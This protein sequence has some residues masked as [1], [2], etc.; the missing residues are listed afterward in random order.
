MKKTII[1]I[2]ILNHIINANSQ[3]YRITSTLFKPGWYVGVNGGLN[4]YIAEGNEFWY[5]NKP[6]IFSI[7][8]NGGFVAHAV[9]GYEFTPLWGLRGSVGY[10][11]HNWP[12]IRINQIIPFNAENLTGDVTLNLSNWWWKSNPRRL[13]SLTAF[14]GIGL[15]HREKANFP[16]DFYAGILRGGIQGDFH[17]SRTM[18]VNLSAEGNFVDDNYNNYVAHTPFEMYAVLTFG[19]TYHLK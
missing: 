17:L 19:V 2:L 9:V 3:S 5:P 1:L 13:V 4:M 12:D 6:Y 14:G 11:Q 8:D 10:L 15:A 18:D 7:K 16:N